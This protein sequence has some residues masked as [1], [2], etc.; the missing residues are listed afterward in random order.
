M[1]KFRETEVKEVTRDNEDLFLNEH[2]MVQKSLWY[3]FWTKYNQN[4]PRHWRTTEVKQKVE[5]S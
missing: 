5:R 3:K 2:S 4:N 1:G